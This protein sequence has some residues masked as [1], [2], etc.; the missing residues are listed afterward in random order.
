LRAAFDTAKAAIAARER[1]EHVT[2]SNPQAYFGKA[3]EEKLAS[4]SA[5]KPLNALHRK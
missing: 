5:A 3:L 2:A 1:R 4:M